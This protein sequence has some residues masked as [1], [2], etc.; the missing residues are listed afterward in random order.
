MTTSIK[1]TN[2][3]LFATAQLLIE[4]GK[5]LSNLQEFRQEAVDL[6][7]KADQLLS[8]IEPEKEKVSRSQMASILD[9]IMNTTG[10][11]Q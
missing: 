10:T 7:I 9:E 6:M 3:T 1:K 4:A 11:V 2:K 8:I 5:T